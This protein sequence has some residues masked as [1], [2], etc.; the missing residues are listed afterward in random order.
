LPVFL[1]TLLTSESTNLVV[2]TQN[3]PEGIAAYDSVLEDDHQRYSAAAA[4]F[5]FSVLAADVDRFT[6]KLRIVEQEQFGEATL[7]AAV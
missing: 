6:N 7:P 1:R 5:G 3:S 2:L 4:K